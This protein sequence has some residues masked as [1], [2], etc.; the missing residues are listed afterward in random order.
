[1]RSSA[2]DFPQAIL[3]ASPV[4]SASAPGTKRETKKKKK[5]I[6]NKT[7]FFGRNKFGV[8]AMMG[9]TNV[10]PFAFATG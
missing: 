8:K 4:L 1:M 7:I 9:R 2:S 3:T 6:I 10:G 5:Y